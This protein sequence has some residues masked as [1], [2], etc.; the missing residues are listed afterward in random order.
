[1]TVALGGTLGVTYPNNSTLTAA[2]VNSDLDPDITNTANVMTI[3]SA[4]VDGSL[5]IYAND[6]LYFSPIFRF[7][8]STN[9]TNADLRTLALAA[10]WNASWP[11]VATINA[12][13][14]V[15]STSTATAGL[16]VTGSFPS[17]VSIIN[18]GNILGMGGLGGGTV[19]TANAYSAAGGGGPAISLGISCTI[20]SASGYIGGG[21]GGG[22]GYTSGANTTSGNGKAAGG[23][24]FALKKG[25]ASGGKGCNWIL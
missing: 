17:G 19:G 1:M 5:G 8:I 7:T 11:V 16:T 18:N 25:Y 13:V 21:G 23:G 20:S 4:V 10:G 3:N 12:G 9:Q 22:G 24:A 15:Y 14:Y 6:E 2:N